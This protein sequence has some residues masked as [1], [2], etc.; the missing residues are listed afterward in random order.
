MKVSGATISL[1]SE[2]METG[3]KV[4]AE[5]TRAQLA[6]VGNHLELAA[7]ES[8]AGTRDVSGGAQCLHRPPSILGELASPFPAF[9]S[10]LHDLFLHV[11]SF[12]QF[13]D[14]LTIE[15]SPMGTTRRTIMRGIMG[16]K[17]DVRG[18]KH[19]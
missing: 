12:L 13:A 18:T 8:L 19:S 5:G 6:E 9:R 16:T 1:E 14:R 17:L 7:T 10:A 3:G 15:D 11:C 4:V 2:A